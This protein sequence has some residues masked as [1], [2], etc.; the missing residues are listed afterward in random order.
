MALCHIL[1]HPQ[2]P[3]FI[4]LKTFSQ[5]LDK[6]IRIFDNLYLN[7]LVLF[8]SFMILNKLFYYSVLTRNDYKITCKQK[9][10]IVIN[11]KVI[12]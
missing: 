5:G 3:S 7:Y 9:Y 8:I 1:F 2:L 12:H 4:F 11:S 6:L 10:Q